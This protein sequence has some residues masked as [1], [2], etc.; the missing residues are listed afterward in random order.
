MTTLICDTKDGQRIHAFDFREGYTRW[1]ATCEKNGD[2][3]ADDDHTDRDHDHP[4]L[5]LLPEPVI[6]PCGCGKLIDPDLHYGVYVTRVAYIMYRT[7]ECA[8]KH[9]DADFEELP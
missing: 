2:G 7:R 1:C 8:W 9:D 4:F 5:R 3:R 6:C